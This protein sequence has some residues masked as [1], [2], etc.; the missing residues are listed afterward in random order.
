MRN[1]PYKGTKHKDI[2]L[3]VTDLI[4]ISISVRKI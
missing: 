1:V 2:Q 3:F 4:Q